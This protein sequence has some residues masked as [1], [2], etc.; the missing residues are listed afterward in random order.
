MLFTGNIVSKDDVI[1][2]RQYTYCKNLR[3]CSSL[4]ENIYVH[5]SEKLMDM[6]AKYFLNSKHSESRHNYNV[7]EDPLIEITIFTY[8][9]L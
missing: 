8:L 7:Y 6:C 3:N 2:N 4:L 5:R 1:T 9:I